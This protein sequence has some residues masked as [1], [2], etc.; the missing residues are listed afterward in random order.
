MPFKSFLL[1]LN[2]DYFMQKACPS[3]MGFDFDAS[4]SAIRRRVLEER[5][6]TDIDRETAASIWGELESIECGGDD[7]GHAFVNALYQIGKLQHVTQE[8]YEYAKE[9]PSPQAIGF[10]REL[11]PL[12]KAELASEVRPPVYSTNSDR[13]YGEPRCP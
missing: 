13:S 9:R 10:W 12:L 3:Y 4:L 1:G 6:A 8:P 11:W 2:F 5:R 7:G